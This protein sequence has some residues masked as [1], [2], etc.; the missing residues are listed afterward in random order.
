MPFYQSGARLF[1]ILGV[2]K[3]GAAPAARPPREGEKYF[4]YFLVF[5]NVWG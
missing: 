3:I 5:P 1:F 4:G 2:D